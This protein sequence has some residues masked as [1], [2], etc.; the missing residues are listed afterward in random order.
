MEKTKIIYPL[1]KLIFT[2]ISILYLGCDKSN[3][4][5]DNNDVKLD[6]NYSGFL[7]IRYTNTLPE[8]D[9]STQISA[10]IDKDLGVILFD[11]GILS[12]SGETMTEDDSKISREGTWNIN[13]TGFF[14]QIGDSILIEVDGGVTVVNDVQ[15]I[16]GKDDKGQWI[17]LNETTFNETPDAQLVFSLIE[18]QL[19]GSIVSVEETT[20]SIT[21]TLGL[22]PAPN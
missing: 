7:N 13:P 3:P 15:K 9:V 12:Y 14:K 17:L 19:N 11:S 16:W 1:I 2:L 6:Y 20:G 8:W 10:D 22:T 18:A 4:D 21:W 5:N